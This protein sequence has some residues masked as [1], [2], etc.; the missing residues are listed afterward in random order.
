MVNGNFDLNYVGIFL[1]NK[2]SV[3]LINVYV[4]SNIC[5]LVMILLVIF[6]FNELVIVCFDGIE[7]EVYGNF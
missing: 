7:E 5:E 4:D 3:N 1:S 6:N 2:N